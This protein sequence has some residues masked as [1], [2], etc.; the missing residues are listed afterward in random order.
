MKIK[1]L[2]Y[3]QRFDH[4]Y[5]D[6]TEHWTRI[7]PLVDPLYK[8]TPLL[9]T[10]VTNVEIVWNIYNVHNS[11]PYEHRILNSA[12]HIQTQLNNF[13][14]IS[15]N[16][17]FNL[18]QCLYLAHS[19]LEVSQY[20]VEFT[21]IPPRCYGMYRVELINSWCRVIQITNITIIC[22]AFKVKSLH[23]ILYRIQ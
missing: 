13:T 23:T 21:I 20:W 11:F 2:Q 19:G 14:R 16:R 10:C 8:K 12:W 9:L 22:S 1:F 7:F 4:Q 6:Q 3:G 15:N 18:I 5:V 17:K